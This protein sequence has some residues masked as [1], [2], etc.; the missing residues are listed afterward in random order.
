MKKNILIFPAGTEIAFEIFNALKYSKFVKLFGGTS[1]DD[2]SEFVF[3]NLIKGFPY[4]DNEDFLDYLNK[5]IDDYKI[6]CVYPAHD[7]VS[8]FLSDNSTKIHAQVIIADKE[9]TDICRSKKATYQYLS[10]EDF[11]PKTFESPNEVDK[12]PVFVKP[13]VGQGSNGA[14]LVKTKE[15]L[16]Q[17]F[18]Q[19]NSLVICENLSGP[20]YTIDCF[21][22][23]NGELLVSHI[24]ERQRIRS[25]ISVRSK[26]INIDA[27]V[28]KIAQIINSKFHFIGA[29]FFQ[30]KKDDAGNLKLLEISPRVPGTMGLS[31]NLGINFPLLTLFVFWGYDVSILDNDY[32]I[33]LDR[34]FYSAYKIDLNYEY[35]YVDFDDTLIVDG[36]VNTELIKYLYQSLN[37]NKHIILL[38]KHDTDIYVDLKKFKISSDLF[39]EIIVISRNELKYNFVKHFNAI[40]IDD[41]FAERKQIHDKL[42]I[43]VFD[44]DMVE[45]LLSWKY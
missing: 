6:D 7:S 8:V 1:T 31:R 2:H 16:M 33:M 44:L 39:D 45:S 18:L 19:D 37:N 22:D 41:S 43:P 32:N 12:Y 23:K 13:T 5:V 11:V 14:R 17:A 26:K 35:I 40:F 36:K 3:E 21:T 34:A 24:R 9:T 4:V 29:W 20:E 30:L 10:N 42:G 25:G 15:E 27:S 38:S 28:E